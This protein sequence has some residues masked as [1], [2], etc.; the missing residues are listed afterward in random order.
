MLVSTLNSVTAHTLA[1]ITGPLVSGSA[2]TLVQSACHWA[3]S[4]H[5][6]AIYHTGQ[7]NEIETKLMLTFASVIV[8]GQVIANSVGNRRT[9]DD[10]A[11]E[12]LVEVVF[13][14]ANAHTIETA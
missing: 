13:L 9:V 5:Q 14:W 10:T 12:R 7:V 3:G 2:R 1:S 8:H 11:E 6:S 4:P